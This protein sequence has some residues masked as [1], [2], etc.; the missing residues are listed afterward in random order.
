MQGTIL[1]K[2]SGYKNFRKGQGIIFQEVLYKGYR[3]IS[4]ASIS[5]QY[6]TSGCIGEDVQLFFS[7]RDDHPSVLYV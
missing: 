3:Y 5:N 1:Q 7:A 2:A 6:C 4:S